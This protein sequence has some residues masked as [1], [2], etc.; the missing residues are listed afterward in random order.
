MDA[1]AEHDIAAAEIAQAIGEPTRARM[2]YALMDGTAHTAT[3][4]S[5][6][7]DI[8]ASTASAHLNR[9]KAANLVTVTAQGKHRYYSLSSAEVARV[10]ESLSVIAGPRGLAPGP[11]VPARLREA[12]ACY[13][14]MAGAVGVAVHD[15]LVA[16]GWIRGV[17]GD[18]E[19][20]YEVTPAGLDGFHLLGV[21]VEAARA[22]RRRFACA[23]LDWSE[24][25]PHL[26]GALGAE[27]LKAWLKQRWIVADLDSRAL[28]I[29]D[30]G[31]KEMAARLDVQ[32]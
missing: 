11:R 28:S 2:L 29:T 7:A 14:H 8:G 13:D 15:R 32:L 31:R 4:L 30:K 20:N 24:R 3:E 18:D 6:I 12:R 21:D 25:R 1:E 27:V 26:A 5:V 22:Q 9:L 17:H 16:R 19:R 23:C 10:L